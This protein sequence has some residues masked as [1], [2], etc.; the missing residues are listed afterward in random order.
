GPAQ[1]QQEPRE[2][3]R[4]PLSAP[5][6]QYYQQRPEE[7]QQLLQRFPIP[8][9]SELPAGNRLAPGVEPAGGSW[10]SLTNPINVKLANPILLTDGTVIANQQLC[11]GNWWKFTPDI[12]GN[13]IN[14]T[15]TQI[16]SLTSTYK[17]RFFGSGVLPDGRVIIEG[18]EYN[19]VNCPSN[20]RT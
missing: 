12:N 5:R 19:G 3:A 10:T 1:T 2:Y 17:P 6:Y 13:Y 20:S 9:A 4:P 16:A 15:W 11:T 7:F 18:G 14:G 8:F